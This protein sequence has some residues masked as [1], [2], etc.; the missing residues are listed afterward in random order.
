MAITTCKLTD[1]KKSNI[2]IIIFRWIGVIFL[3]GIEGRYVLIVERAHSDS[4][5]LD[6]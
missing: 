2:G 1:S 5:I 6:M 3:V 4:C